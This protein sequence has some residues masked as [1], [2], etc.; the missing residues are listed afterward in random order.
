V[1]NETE[2]KEHILKPL[3]VALY[4]AKLVANKTCFEGLVGSCCGMK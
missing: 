2:I 4:E 3:I 1:L